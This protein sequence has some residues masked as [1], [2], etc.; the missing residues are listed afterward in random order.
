[1]GQPFK[2][3]IHFLPLTHSAR[4]RRFFVAP[5]R[6]LLDRVPPCFAKESL[7]FLSTRIRL[8]LRRMGVSLFVHFD[9]SGDLSDQ[10]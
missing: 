7:G 6:L 3:L 10:R 9:S 1:M 8:M 5:D 4:G 2:A